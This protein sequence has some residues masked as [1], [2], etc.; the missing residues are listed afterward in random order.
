MKG[1]MIIIGE[2]LRQRIRCII[3]KQWKTCKHR[4]ECL[5]KLGISYRDAYVTSN[6]R[7]DYYHIAHTRVLEQAISKEMLNKRGLVNLLDHYLKV[8]IITN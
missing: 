7:R 5:L 1:N 4:H 8:H 2:H 3:W 6:S